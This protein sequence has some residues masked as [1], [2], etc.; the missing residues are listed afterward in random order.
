VAHQ[1]GMTDVQAEA[2]EEMRRQSYIQ[3]VNDTLEQ[4]KMNNHLNEKSQ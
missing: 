2:M 3:G 4:N 1:F